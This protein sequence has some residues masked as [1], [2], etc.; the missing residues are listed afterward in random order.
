MEALMKR[1]L[2][3]V[4]VIGISSAAVRADITFVQTTTMEGGAAAAMVPAGANP[5]TKITTRVKGLKSRTD[6]EVASSVKSSSIVDIAAKQMIMLQHDAKTVQTFDGSAAAGAAAPVPAP[7]A[8]LTVDATTPVPT[9]KSQQIDGLK[10][11][12]YTFTTTMNLSDVTG[13]KLP[14]E[15]AELMKG[16]TMV[17]KGSMWVAKTAP[18][19]AEFVAYQQALAKADLTS[20]VLKMTGV[21]VPGLDKIL[22]ATTSVD[23]LPYLTVIDMKLEG[24]GQMADMMRQMM[25]G[26]KIT[27]KLTSLSAEAIGDEAFK[28]PDGYTVVK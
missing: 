15:A 20:T 10:C 13:E 2:A 5:S 27:S 14:P 3:T 11:D 24:T 16:L 18:G 8:T 6:M 19:V 25:G 17:M 21:S 9:G 28:V 4:L 26:M 23:G 7:V 22:K 12:E 1:W